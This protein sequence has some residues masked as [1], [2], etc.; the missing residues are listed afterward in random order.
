MRVRLAWRWLRYGAGMTVLAA[1][2]VLSM[3]CARQA[4]VDGGP[5]RPYVDP[6]PRQI[7]SYVSDPNGFRRYA[8]SKDWHGQARERRC[9]GSAEC[10]T[11]PGSRTTRVSVEAI[12]FADSVDLGR[13]PTTGVLM[14]RLENEGHFEEDTYRLRPGRGKGNIEYY[15]VVEP[16]RTAQ[17]D[18]GLPRA[19]VK[20]VTWTHR[21]PRLEIDT[22][23]AVMRACRDKH[24]PG[25]KR[26]GADFTGCP[27]PSQTPPP[28]SAPLDA[29]STSMAFVDRERAL[30]WISCVHGC[31]EI[32]AQ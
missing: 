4:E 10:G 20:L 19:M 11:G 16:L 22:L 27:L 30:T 2:A 9:R 21:A 31:C 3:S 12:E 26:P 7:E 14:A 15:V 6:L 32:E 28:G 23:G 13:L 25:H 5:A 29:N 24:E 1:A 18:P 17:P 8:R